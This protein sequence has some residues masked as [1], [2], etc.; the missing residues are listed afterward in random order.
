MRGCMVKIIGD[1]Y[2]KNNTDT[3]SPGSIW[4]VI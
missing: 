1:I 3:F 4:D 2:N